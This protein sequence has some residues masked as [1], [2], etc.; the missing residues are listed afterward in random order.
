LFPDSGYYINN[1][2]SLCSVCH[3]KAETTEISVEQIRAACKIEETDKILPPQ[4]YDDQQYDKWGNPILPNKTRLRGELFDDPS[5]QKVLGEGNALNLF[6]K[7]VKYPRTWHLP[8]SPGI[9][10]DDRVIPS[11]DQFVGKNIV[12][13]VKMDGE[14]CLD[15]ETL[16]TT[17]D[18]P[19]SIK[20]LCHRDGVFEVLSFNHETGQQEWK[21]VE[22]KR[23]LSPSEGWYEIELE[24]GQ[25]IRL[26]GEHRI[27][28]ENLSCYRMVKDLDGSEELR[29]EILPEKTERR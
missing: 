25:S 17:R 3:Y 22:A 29:M 5:V 16:I 28:C 11:C 6:T 1:G 15:G 10:K 23:I 19:V 13:T 21:N 24:N 12:V 27:W 20:E 7:Y 2:S 9:T 4:L 8:W 18:G 14:N 26:T